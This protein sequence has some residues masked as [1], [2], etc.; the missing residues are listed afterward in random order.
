MQAKPVP[1]GLF[2]TITIF[3]AFFAG[4][5]HSSEQ[6]LDPV[7]YFRKKNAARQY[8][9]API[10]DSIILSGSGKKMQVAYH[11]PERPVSTQYSFRMPEPEYKIKPLFSSEPYCP[12]Q[13]KYADL[14]ELS[15]E[16]INNLPLY[17]FIENWYGVR[18]KYGGNDDSGIDCSAFV[19]LLYGNVYCT[20]LV[21]TSL[22]QFRNCRFIR[23]K[24]SLREGHL[25]FFRTR[26]KKR[27]NH[28]GIYLANS[29]FVHASATQGVVISNLDDTY[30][31]RTYAGAGEIHRQE[32]EIRADGASFAE[33]YP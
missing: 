1:Y 12:L 33:V 22:E 10:P 16:E 29:Y 26:G 13:V 25:V 14:L 17:N 19:Q 31:S 3:I 7:S 4:G 24:D 9:G 8:A 15:P 2:L 30:W 6:L 21:R 23:K 27:I 5:C 28:V 11:V 32:E 20:D 18:Y